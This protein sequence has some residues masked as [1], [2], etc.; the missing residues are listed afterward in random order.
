ML[1]THMSGT[2]WYAEKFVIGSL[3]WFIGFSPPVER[4]KKQ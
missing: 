2:Q 4:V 1:H 3:F